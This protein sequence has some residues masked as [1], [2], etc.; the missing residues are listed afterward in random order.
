MLSLN[1]LKLNALGVSDSQSSNLLLEDFSGSVG[2]WSLRKIGNVTNVVR[3][4]RS[5][6]NTESDFTASQVQNG[7][8]L[9]WV[10][11]FTS[12]YSESMYF[13]G[14]DDFISVPSLSGNLESI[15]IDFINSE[16]INSSSAQTLFAWSDSQ[17]ANAIHIGIWTGALANEV[18]SIG[19]AIDGSRTA[20]VSITI[21]PGLHNLLLQWNSGLSRY[22]IILDGV[23]QSVVSAG[24]GHVPLQP[25][26]SSF[27]GKR[28]DGGFGTLPFKGVIKNVN[29]NEGEYV[30]VGDGNIN[31]NWLNTGSVSG[32]NGNVSG[33]PALFTGQGYNGFVTTWYDQTGNGRNFVQS[34]AINQPIIVENGTLSVSN[35]KPALKMD[36]NLRMKY[37]DGGALNSFRQGAL[38]AFSVAQLTSRT[39]PWQALWMPTTNGSG[40]G[41]IG[42]QFFSILP[43]EFGCHNSNNTSAGVSVTLSNTLNQYLHI[44][45]RN[46]SGVNGNGATIELES[47]G[48]SDNPT[49]SVVQ[50]WTSNIGTQFTLGKQWDVDSDASVSHWRGYIQEVVLFGE[51]KTT[52]VPEI[53]SNINKHY[54]IY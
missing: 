28:F 39:G 5:T 12:I 3:I 8:L 42:Q 10:S 24:P 43:N 40:N 16:V 22:D 26:G 20:V 54:R 53:K 21:N 27:I 50:S 45:T 9:N 44:M 52:E 7:T 36:F 15:S 14:V 2:A 17:D 30:Y 51:Q 41:S 46:S 37:V 33:S 47:V 34:T 29:I 13:D 1:N 11:P 35:G 6:D 31:A 18:I 49:A 4:R 23:T 19:S 25:L 32:S 48:I 38:S